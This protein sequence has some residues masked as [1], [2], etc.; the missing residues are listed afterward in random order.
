MVRSGRWGAA[1]TADRLGRPITGGQGYPFRL[2]SHRS[3]QR[4]RCRAAAPPTGWSRRPAASITGQA[5]QSANP[6]KVL[7]VSHSAA[8]C[9]G[10]RTIAV[11]RVVGHHMHYALHPGYPIRCRT[12][13]H[14]FCAAW[15]RSIF[16]RAQCRWHL[17]CGRR[18]VQP[19]HAAAGRSTIAARAC[20]LPASWRPVR[21]H[22]WR[23]QGAACL[24]RHQDLGSAGERRHDRTGH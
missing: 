1:C 10:E 21:Y 18:I 17:V 24:L 8:A 22:Q 19:C 20:H 4:C 12:W 2:I 15:A 9:F 3:A 16:D 23:G 11:A 14:P 5:V 13:C 7:R 6:V